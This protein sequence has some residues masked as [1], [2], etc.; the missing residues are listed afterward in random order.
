LSCARRGSVVDRR[1]SQVHHAGELLVGAL[2]D[3]AVRGIVRRFP[4]DGRLDS[5]KYMYELRHPDDRPDLDAEGDAAEVLAK[6]AERF[7]SR[8]GPATVDELTWWS[9]TTKTAAGKALRALD[10]ERLAFPGWTKEAWMLP[11]DMPA[12]RSFNDEGAD[13]IAF[14]PYRDR[15]FTCA[16]DRQ[17]SRRNRAFLFWTAR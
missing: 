3:L 16:A 11:R 17:S 6:A 7:L 14:L 4:I 1:S 8:H 5:A 2:N 9:G 15:S 10:A 13:R 12:W